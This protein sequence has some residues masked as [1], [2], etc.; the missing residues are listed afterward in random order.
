MNR[1]PGFR[2]PCVAPSRELQTTLKNKMVS[3]TKLTERK[4]RNIVD[5]CDVVWTK[6][7]VCSNLTYLTLNRVSR[8]PTLR[9]N[10]RP[11]KYRRSTASPV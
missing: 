1:K 4:L 10:L 6:L 3:R 7:K 9:L 11:S 5:C 2:A 8:A